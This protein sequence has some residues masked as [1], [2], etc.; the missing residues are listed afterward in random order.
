MNKLTNVKSKTNNILIV[1]AE[2]SSCMYAKL[3]IK[4]WKGLYPNVHFFGVGDK[5]MHSRGM[6]CV[7]LA[8][9]M[10]V[11]GLHEVLFHWREIKKSF[12]SL[13]EMAERKKPR[14]AL[15]LDYPGFNL[16][17]AF[18]LKKLD[19]PVVYYLSPQL[20]AWKEGRVKYIKKFV[21]DM[22]VVFPFEVDFY[23]KHGIQAHFVGHPL[24]EIMNQETKTTFFSDRIS[25]KPVLG[26]MPGSRKSEIKHNLKIQWLTAQKLM[27]NYDIDVKLLTAPTFEVNFLKQQLPKSSNSIEFIKDNPIIMI[28]KCDFI[29]AAS[30]TAT[31]QVALCEKPMVVMYRMNGLT[32]FLA[33]FLTRHINYYC[34]VNLIAGRE[35]VPEFMQSKACPKLLAKELEKILKFPDY[36]KKMVSSLKKISKDLG[37]KKAT[38]NLVEFLKKKYG[39]K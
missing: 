30:G 29:L 15:L 13:V 16:R 8:E 35:I 18:R 31:L 2:A 21:D 17:L 33:K 14:F 1:A 37:S 24:V 27:E 9:D 7:G 5:E 25:S 28:K 39:N 22:M 32:A 23:K 6:E 11:V 20:W 34:I 4:T 38:E 19:I 12:H 36:R 10:A 26:L 3:F